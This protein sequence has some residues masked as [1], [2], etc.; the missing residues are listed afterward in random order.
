MRNSVV[1][2]LFAASFAT[3]CVALP[4]AGD[5]ILKNNIY[6]L[7]VPDKSPVKFDSWSG[8][9]FAKF[10]GA[11]VLTGTFRYGHLSELDK[12]YDLIGLD[13]TPDEAVAAT[14]PHWSGPL[15]LDSIAFDNPSD[16]IAAVIPV[17][18]V[19]QIKQKK[20]L[21]VAGRITIRVDQYATFATCSTPVYRVRFVEVVK[22]AEAQV[23][24]ITADE[25][26]C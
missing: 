19:D 6:D 3:T 9:D 25:S 1:T 5:T 26:G 23:S 14:L 21:S 24:Q 10:H 16:F 2:A 15:K 11:F 12:T 22:P 7:I 18:A 13:F 17:A 4:S 8:F 20:L